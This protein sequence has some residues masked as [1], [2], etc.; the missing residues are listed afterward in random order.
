MADRILDA[1]DVYPAGEG[2]EAVHVTMA[3]MTFPPTTFDPPRKLAPKK[4]AVTAWVNDGRW[5]VVCPNCNEGQVVSKDD[6]RFLC[7]VCKNVVVDGGWRQVLFPDDVPG[8]ESQLLRRAQFVNRAWLPGE[9]V[10]DLKAEWDALVVV[11]GSSFDLRV[12]FD[13]KRKRQPK[14]A[15]KVI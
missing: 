14:S 5:V 13:E 4:D 8:I 6:H 2:A 9:T 11:G 1:A 15:V 10:E 7:Y 12:S 3:A